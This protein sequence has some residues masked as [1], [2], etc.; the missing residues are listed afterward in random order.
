MQFKGVLSVLIFSQILTI[1]VNAE[2]SQS[3]GL[4]YQGSQVGVR[5]IHDKIKLINE[6]HE[7]VIIDA[8]I[9][10]DTYRFNFA[11]GEVKISKGKKFYTLKEKT[12][13]DTKHKKY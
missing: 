7:A 10:G 9:D 6:P 2:Q 5:S 11:N 3:N 4:L 8:N 13:K 12:K 1:N